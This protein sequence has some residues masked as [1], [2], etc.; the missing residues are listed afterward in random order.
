MKNKKIIFTSVTILIICLAC[1][2][3]VFA[4]SGRTDS[5]GGHRDNKNSSGLGSYHY[6]C[7][8]YPPH[9]HSGGVC[10][11][12]G[13]G[14]YSSS[15]SGQIRKSYESESKTTTSR[16]SEGYDDGYD[17]GYDFGYDRGYD[18]G[19][20]DGYV[21]GYN[22]YEDEL[23]EVFKFLLIP[24]GVIMVIVLLAIIFIK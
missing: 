23:V 20:A 13:G 6:H 16:Y 17:A 8:G 21:K 5:S 3:N 1:V 18:G 11:Y 22:A 9:L 2:F 19:H 10:P 7:G 12:T 14:S 4:H 24:I 15:S